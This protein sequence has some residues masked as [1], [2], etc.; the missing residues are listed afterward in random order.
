MDYTSRIKLGAEVSL[1]VCPIDDFTTE[2]R[3][4]DNIH[5]FIK[6]M[7]ISPIRKFDGYFAFTGLPKGQYNIKVE[8]DIYFNENI[9]V[10]IRELDSVEQPVFITL[11]PRPSYN[12][13]GGATLIRSMLSDK[14]GKAPNDAQ[15][16]ATVLSDNCARAKLSRDGANKGDITVTLVDITGF[17][18]EGDNFLLKDKDNGNTEICEV[19]KIEKGAKSFCL[20]K[21]LE[22]NYGRGAILLPTVFTRANEKGE[23]VVYFRNLHNKYFDA[24]LE[25]LYKDKITTKDVRVEEGKTVNLGSIQI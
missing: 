11:K 19:V 24:Q 1:V 23:I 17:I 22:N 4:G 2:K 15:V 7:L 21:P 14:E 25:F 16:K 18:K 3:S 20:S 10:S 6:D 9:E 8:S 12:F 13:P 5:V